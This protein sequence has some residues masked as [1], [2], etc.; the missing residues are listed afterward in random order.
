MYPTPHY[1]ILGRD[2]SNK[3]E[4]GI[5]LALSIINDPETHRDDF[6]CSTCYMGYRLLDG[7]YT[8]AHFIFP[9]IQEA[10]AQAHTITAPPDP[11][12]FRARWISSL[13]ILQIYIKLLI[14]KE[15]V[16]VELISS[17]ANSDH[18][19]NHP[20]QL[21][22][23]MR[24]WAMLILYYYTI[25]QVKLAHKLTQD[26]MNVYKKSINLNNIEKDVNVLEI[27]EATACLMFIVQVK[28]T[29][30]DGIFHR[31]FYVEDLIKL[32]IENKSYGAYYRSLYEIYKKDAPSTK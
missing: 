27:S 28:G 29:T 7:T 22:N 14:F 25:N 3:P 23:V 24:G 30:Q 10:Y 15:D 4:V 12:W 26:A 13:T 8:D 16:P 17:L 1:K 5:P 19:F 6:L 31:E 32:E 21:P 9:K 2:L 11:E 20:P 18:A